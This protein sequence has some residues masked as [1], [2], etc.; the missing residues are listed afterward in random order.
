MQKPHAVVSRN[1]H[2]SGIR[3]GADSIVRRFDPARDSYAQLT[4]MHCIAHSR[5]SG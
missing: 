3:H 5:G 4:A 1:A 2:C